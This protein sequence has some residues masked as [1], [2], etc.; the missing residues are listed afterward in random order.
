M[1]P[2]TLADLAGI[3]SKAYPCLFFI[4]QFV[5]CFAVPSS[6]SK[7]PQSLHHPAGTGLRRPFTRVSQDELRQILTQLRSLS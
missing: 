3:P 2:M 6:T 1:S 5:S 4:M 7:L